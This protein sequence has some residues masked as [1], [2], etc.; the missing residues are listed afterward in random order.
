[1]ADLLAVGRQ[2]DERLALFVRGADK[3]IWQL[4]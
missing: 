2:L 4:C 1:V 3:A